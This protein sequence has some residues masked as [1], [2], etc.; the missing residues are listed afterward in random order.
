MIAPP[1]LTFPPRV[2][3]WVRERYAAARVILEYGSGGSTILAAGMPGKTVF[4]VESD[5]AWAESMQAVLEAGEYPAT[6]RLHHVDIGPTGKWGRPA[7]GAGFRRYHRYP[8][9]VWE[10]PDFVQPDLVLIDGRFRLACALT[11]MLLT[12]RPLT[13]LFDDYVNRRAYHAIERFLDVAETRGRMARFEVEP[14]A[15]PREGFSVIAGAFA[16]AN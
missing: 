2:A 4:S 11:T 1:V 6:V 15:L 16:K 5:K 12:T 13:L 7:D 10:R 14:R 8:V 9:S 3:D